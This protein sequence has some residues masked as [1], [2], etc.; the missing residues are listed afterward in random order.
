MSLYEPIAACLSEY[1]DIKATDIHPHSTMSDLG[2][3][4]LALVELTCVAHD[5]LGLHIPDNIL[6]MDSTLAQVVAA[7]EEAQPCPPTADTATTADDMTAS[8][9]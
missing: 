5:E 2:L 4:S 7:L 8:V 9:R 1:F 3:D 6:P